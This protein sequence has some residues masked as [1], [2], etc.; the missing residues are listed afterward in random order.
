MKFGRALPAYLKPAVGEFCARFSCET[1]RGCTCDTASPQ[2][3]RK[4]TGQRL[5]ECALVLMWDRAAQPLI[6][7]SP[8]SLLTWFLTR[9]GPTSEALFCR[10][11]YG[12]PGRPPS[13]RR[14]AKC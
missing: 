1:G 13:C 14:M 5:T 4:R 2:T 9:I 8:S 10:V 11:D 3:C 12:P 6:S 7:A